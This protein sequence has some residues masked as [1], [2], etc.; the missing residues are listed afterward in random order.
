MIDLNKPAQLFKILISLVTILPFHLILFGSLFSGNI[1]NNLFD[2]FTTL[3]D[4]G[5]IGTYIILVLLYLFIPN[6][7]LWY[8]CIKSRA[9][10]TEIYMQ[11]S[12]KTIFEEYIS[13]FLYLYAPLLMLCYFLIF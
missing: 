11:A 3:L 7:K 2:L 5:I 9:F 10:N 13:K 8:L 12:A 6:I 4:N 1:R